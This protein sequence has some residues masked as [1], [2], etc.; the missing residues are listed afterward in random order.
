MIG[1]Q[2][3]KLLESRLTI[4]EMIERDINLGRSPRYFDIIA[5]YAAWY[6]ACVLLFIVCVGSEWSVARGL[7]FFSV[8]VFVWGVVGQW[9][10]MSGRWANHK[11]FIETQRAKIKPPPIAARAQVW[12][13]PPEREPMPNSIAR[14]LIE[15]PPPREFIE[16]C[17]GYAQ[18]RG[19][20]PSERAAMDKFPKSATNEWLD[21]LAKYQITVE[22]QSVAK[23]NAENLPGRWNEDITLERALAT[24]G[25][26]DDAE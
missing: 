16:W 17:F 4:A 24:F 23:G 25:Q 19:K 11:I 21:L 2:F 22:R 15:N 1:D 26:D 13:A 7:V 5:K 10:E 6:F 9:L 12:V 3:D 8:F 18:A 20:M 14:A